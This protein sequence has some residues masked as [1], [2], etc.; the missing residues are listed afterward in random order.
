MKPFL[1][2]LAVSLLGSGAALA[3]GPAPLSPPVTEPSVNTG[4]AAPVIS[5][6]PALRSG[7]RSSS[8]RRRSAQHTR[9]RHRAAAHRHRT[10][11]K[12]HSR[13]R[14]AHR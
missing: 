14:G 3:Q 6:H 4:H 11:A 7:A 9:R 1:R 5:T 2:V 13:A 10:V 12:R 8:H